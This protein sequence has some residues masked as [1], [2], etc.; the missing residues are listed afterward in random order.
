MGT[1]FSLSGKTILVT[2]ASSGIGREIAIS[3]SKLG[4]KVVLV[5][6]D[7]TRLDATLQAMAGEGHVVFEANL[8]EESQ[9]SDLLSQVPPLH[10]FVHAA[11]VAKLVPAK[12]L[13]ES[14]INGVIGINYTAAMLMVQGLLKKKLLLNNCSIVFISSIAGLAGMKANSVYAGTKGALIA[15]ARALAIELAGSKIRVNC[16]APGMV[17]TPLTEGTKSMVSEESMLLDEAKY[18]LGYG[19]PEDVAN[20]AVFL[21]S[22]ASRWITGSTLV[23]DGGRT[24]YV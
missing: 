24:S 20:S 21:L 3:V 17:R 23:V 19:L 2:G 16:I 1:P 15:S 22:E 11:G 13:S 9:R 8:A 4:G 10:G 14:A 12:F 18:P 6:R 5:A 7:R